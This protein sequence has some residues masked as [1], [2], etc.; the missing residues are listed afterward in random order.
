MLLRTSSGILT[1]CLLVAAVGSL[2]GRSLAADPLP[3]DTKPDWA[4][5]EKLLTSGSYHEAATVAGDLA[6]TVKAKRRAPDFLP[7]TIERVRALMRRGLA[8][9]RLGDV[10]AADEA[11]AEATRDY[12][13]REFQRLLALEARN[14]TAA[15]AAQMAMLEVN[16]VELVDFRSLAVLERMKAANRARRDSSLRETGPPAAVPTSLLD[17]VSRWLGELKVLKRAGANARESLAE[18]FEKGGPAVVASPYTR[19]VAGSFRP[20]M[21]AGIAAREL[22]AMPAEILQAAAVR[23][24]IDAGDQEADEDAASQI[25]ARLLEDSLGHFDKAA[26]ALEEGIRAASPTGATGL[27]GDARIEAAL[28]EAEIMVNRGAVLQQRAELALA[29][30]GFRRAVQLQREVGELR[31][32]PSP[33]VHPDMFWPLLLDAEATLEEA[34][35]LLAGGDHEASQAT[36]REAATTLARAA[37]LPVSPDHPLRGQLADLQRRLHQERTA[38]GDLLPRSEAA[39]AAARRL[40]EA[41]DATALPGIAP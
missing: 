27:R 36:V 16:G 24:W 6:E 20:E 35:R 10:D 23:D 22:A 39:D 29:R 18:R 30:E 3:P 5:L 8:L 41:I 28:L 11:F 40:R 21:I 25:R 17:D 9:L 33:D 2:G 1:A 15:V 4:A 14:A 32:S 31:R 26:A 38:L 12:K 37:A 34:R 19:A 13:D 7:R